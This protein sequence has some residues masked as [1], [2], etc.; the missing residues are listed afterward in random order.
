MEGSCACCDRGGQCADSDPPGRFSC[1]CHCSSSRGS[2]SSRRSRAGPR[3]PSRGPRGGSVRRELRRRRVRRH[4]PWSRLRRRPGRRPPADVDTGPGAATRRATAPTCRP[5]PR[6]APSP[7]TTA[8]GRESS[9]SRRRTSY[10]RTAAST[11]TGRFGYPVVRA[12]PVKDVVMTGYFYDARASPGGRGAV[13]IEL[14]R[15][16]AGARRG[17]ELPLEAYGMVAGRA[18]S[19]RLRSPR[20]SAP[21]ALDRAE[22]VADAARRS[23]IHLAPWRSRPRFR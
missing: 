12:V 21:R 16:D 17:P 19:A 6:P 4:R 11:I 2:A 13:A 3:P 14:V 8:A 9:A 10:G 20:S 15:R 5:R 23:S 22:Q 18:A 1:S 7:S